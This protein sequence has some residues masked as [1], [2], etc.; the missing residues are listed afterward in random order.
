[1]RRSRY[2]FKTPRRVYRS[3]SAEHVS[4]P[5]WFQGSLV[6]AI[7]SAANRRIRLIVMTMTGTDESTAFTETVHFYDL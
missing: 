2:H 3:L 1:M 7:S 5:S 4:N 6:V